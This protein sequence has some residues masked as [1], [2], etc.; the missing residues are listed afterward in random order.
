MDTYIINRRI[1]SDVEQ[2]MDIILLDNWWS[3]LV[4]VTWLREI[5]IYNTLL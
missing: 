3:P 1:F 5:E 2:F 4:S